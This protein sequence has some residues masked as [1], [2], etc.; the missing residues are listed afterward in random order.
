MPLRWRL[1]IG[2]PL[3][4]SLLAAITLS[5]AFIHYT[6]RFP[7]PSA[8]RRK[9]AA[10]VVRL[11]ARDGSVLAERGQPYGFVPLEMMPRHL[12]DAVVA[13]EDRRFFDHIGL[14]FAGFARAI[15]A[16]IRAG[17]YAQ[18]GSTLTQQLAKNLFLTS[19]RTLGRKLEELVLALWLEVRLSKRDIIELYLNRV[20][21]GGGAYGVEAASRRFFDKGASAL[22]VAE[23]AVLAGLLKAPSKYSPVSSPGLARARGRVVLAKMI[24]AGAITPSAAAEAQRLPVRFADPA[25]G[26]A[27]TGLE[28]A[29]EFVLERLP[30][31]AGGVHREIIVETTLDGSLQ[32]SAQAIV[33]RVL[34]REGSEARA[35][36]AALVLLDMEGGI[37]A[38]VGGRSWALSQFNR[39]VKAQRQPGSAFKPIVYLTAIEQGATPHTT[40]L[41][42]PLNIGGWSPRNDNGQHRGAMPLRLALAHSVNTVAVRLQ[43]DAGTERVI[44]TARR[45]G[46][47][48]DLR[49]DPSLALGTSEVNLLELTGAYGILASGGLEV[50]PHAI[51][52]VRT[53]DGTVLYERQRRQPRM[54]VAP[55]HAGIMNSMLNT[56]LVSGTGRRAA[57]PRF[58]AAGKTG[59]TQDFR[60]A[61][62]V[63]Y[64]SH[65][66]AGVWVG[67]DA[68]EPMSR[69]VGGGL[70]AS[71]WREVML[72][73]HTH[74]LPTPLPGA[75][76]EPV[77]PRPP[78]MPLPA[79]ATSDRQPPAPPRAPAAR[80]PFRHAPVAIAPR[81]ASP[82]IAPA[83]PA[84]SPQAAARSRPGVAFDTDGLQRL[85]VVPLGERRMGLGIKP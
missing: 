74:M 61:W 10:P 2:L 34:V 50:A 23:A 48:S 53:S 25:A 54:I 36:Q 27:A 79:A 9:E 33:E 67:N 76:I 12:I 38:I 83:L 3:T 11:L 17:R 69:V 18:G 1:L 46:I 40:A 59:T 41:D 37:R 29:I 6:I 47:R 13:T 71:I 21:F 14:D 70:P 22:T 16:N 77:A 55:D 26:R 81:P 60:D 85:L 80:R 28:Y 75:D 32:K 84:A 15:F 66:T 58:P 82:A 68:G 78:A 19:Q 62:F 39:A 52:R 24:D 44:A 20:Y 4:A 35:G 49:A 43:Q 64:T 51:R 63:G 31:L 42:M 72:V 5:V 73:A 8:L 7:D 30:Q 56:A 57:L 65:F 45:L